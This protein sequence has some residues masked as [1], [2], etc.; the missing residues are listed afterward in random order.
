MN[1]KSRA[2][3]NKI[4]KV[5]YLQKIQGVRTL[6]KGRRGKVAPSPVHFL[7][8]KSNLRLSRGRTRRKPQRT[9][10]KSWSWKVTSYAETRDSGHRSYKLIVIEPVNGFA[11]TEAEDSARRVLATG[12]RMDLGA[13]HLRFERANLTEPSKVLGALL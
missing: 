3:P 11:M 4:E 13:R 7:H 12:K 2:T 8:F 1:I 9:S 10:T 5:T 6:V